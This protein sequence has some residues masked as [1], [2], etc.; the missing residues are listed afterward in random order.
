VY[1]IRQ[2]RNGITSDISDVGSPASDNLNLFKAFC[3][4]MAKKYLDS[5][6]T[7]WRRRNVLHPIKKEG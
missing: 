7:R 4:F 3:I 5:R 2:I 6:R 1:D